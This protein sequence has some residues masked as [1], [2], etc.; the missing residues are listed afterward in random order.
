MKPQ[1]SPS[2]QQQCFTLRL[3]CT[4]LLMHM[5]ARPDDPEARQRL[6]LCVNRMGFATMNVAVLNPDVML[7][8]SLYNMEEQRVDN[9]WEK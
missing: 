4:E 3:Q 5:N 1:T 9:A 7:R 8:F 2:H 6:V